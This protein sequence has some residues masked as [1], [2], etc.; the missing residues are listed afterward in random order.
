MAG[1][2]NEE[3]LQKAAI[4][5]EAIVNAGRL[6]PKQADRFLDYVWDETQLASL[7]VRT[8]KFSNEKM[9]IDKINVANRVAVAAEEA[10]DPGLR[11]G[12][13]TSKIPLTPKEIMV[14]FELSDLF[15]E[16][17]LEGDSVEDKLIQLFA[18]RFANN[19]E[20]L[21]LDGNALG[22][23]VKESDLVEGGSATLYRKDT[24]LGL[25]N[26]ILKSGEAGHVVDANNAP[27]TPQLISR[28]LRA[29]PNKFRK[30]RRELRCLMSWDHEQ[31]YREGVST[32]ATGAGDSALAGTAEIPSF[33]VMLSPL[34]LM[35]SEPFD[36]VHVQ[37]N[38]DGTTATALGLHSPVSEVVVTP[39]TLG[40]NPVAPYVLG[41]D[42]SQDLAAGTITRLAG[43]A[44]GSGATVKVTFRTAGRLLITMPK[45]IIIAIGR[46]IKIERDRNIYKRVNEFA[47]HGKVFCTFEEPDA[48]V[49]VTNVQVPAE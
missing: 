35:E 27:I 20:Q 26:G 16:E 45:N 4:T 37:V 38:T 23:A 47:M 7:G 11:R 36:T 39:T 44:I 24:F 15:K 40:K 32:R 28:A 9:E 21:H 3:L 43:G 14:P 48:V 34:S 22:P 41:V 25:Y 10:A 2:S 5:T 49:L 1:M 13:S 18:R 6:N 12:I 17:N 31:H 19:V 33:G 46:D 8:E 30:N 42:Y 29:L